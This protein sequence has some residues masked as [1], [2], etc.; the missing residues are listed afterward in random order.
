MQPKTHTLV[1]LIAA[2]STGIIAPSVQGQT[3]T[4]VSGGSGFFE[5]NHWNSHIILSE[6]PDGTVEDSGFNSVFVF[7]RDTRRAERASDGNRVAVIS[8]PTSEQGVRTAN[9]VVVTTATSAR[10]R[11]ARVKDSVSHEHRN[12]HIHPQRIA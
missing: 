9:E 8:T 7:D 2:L 1:L 12:S 5:D 6:Y 10:T 11:K 4:A 3:E